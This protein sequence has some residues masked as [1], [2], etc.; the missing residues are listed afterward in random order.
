MKKKQYIQKICALCMV[1]S[2]LA[3][4]V[5]GMVVSANKKPALNKKKIVIRVGEKSRL[6]MKNTNKKVIWRSQNKIIASVNKNGVVIGRKNGKTTITAQVQKKKY[7]CRVTV[8]AAAKNRSTALPVSSEQPQNTLA[9]TIVPT[10]VIPEQTA[11]ADG[12]QNIPSDAKQTANP[13]QT[14]EVTLAPEQGKEWEEGKISGKKVDFE[15]YF[16]PEMKQYTKK[17]QGVPMGKIE[18]L[19]YHSEVIG[20]DREAYVYLPPEYDSSKKYP[21]LYLLHGI[22]C[23]RGQ[24][25]YMSLN[26][27]LSNMIYKG[28]LQTVV[29]VI[30]SIVPKDGLAQDTFASENIEAFTLFEKEFIQDLEPYVLA[31]YGVSSK[32]EDTGV[33]GLSMGGMEA[34]RLG[35]A[36]KD[37]FNYIGSFSAAPTLDQSILTL[38]GWTTTPQTILLCSGDA[39]ETIGSNP[40]DY[41][42][43]LEENKVDHIW[44]QYPKGKHEEKVWRN[45]LVNFLKRSY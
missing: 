43:K 31:H 25:R 11:A 18:D 1:V 36:I 26:E 37:H 8:K 21:V 7:I 10:P 9:P 19:T 24:W 5:S 41:H 6:Q 3:V 14:P 4:S 38:D 39:D 30:P 34:L 35:F 33:C 40:F 16:N 44:Y 20:A 12:S 45:G 27:I 22:G 32:R 28:E 15:K 29:A 13:A 17:Q 42:R 2:L 23:D